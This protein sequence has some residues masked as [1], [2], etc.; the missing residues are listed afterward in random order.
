MPRGTK[1]G[2]RYGF[3]FHRKALGQSLPTWAYCPLRTTTVTGFYMSPQVAEELGA[4]GGHPQTEAY[5]WFTPGLVQAASAQEPGGLVSLPLYTLAQGRRVYVCNKV[6]RT[7]S[8]GVFCLGPQAR[9][10]SLQRG[11]TGQGTAH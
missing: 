6:T 9:C 8:E 4:P 5:A 11:H 3:Q 7:L 2:S 10:G 1:S